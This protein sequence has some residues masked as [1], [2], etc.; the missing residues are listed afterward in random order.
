[1]AATARREL[2]PRDCVLYVLTQMACAAVGVWLA[3]AMFAAPVWE[4]SHK[5]RDGSGQWLGEFVATFGLMATI[6]GAARFASASIPL[7]VGLYI[8]AAYWF[9]ASTSFANPAVTIARCLTDTFA[10]IAPASAPMFVLAQVAGAVMSYFV[11]RWLFGGVQNQQPAL[12]SAGS[13]KLCRRGAESN[14][15]KRRNA[16]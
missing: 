15:E 13:Q 11:S 1:M 14:S 10:G 5:L 2:T 8:T 9:T 7:L 12:P 3:H 16:G 6:A 4:V